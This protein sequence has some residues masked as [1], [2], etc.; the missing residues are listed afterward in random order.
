MKRGGIVSIFS[1]TGDWKDFYRQTPVTSIIFIINTFMLL[2]TLFTGGFD[3]R[4]SDWA[5]INKI[6][7]FDQGEYY[8]LL[9]GAFQ[10]WSILHY[11]M[12]MIIGIIVLSSALERVIGSKKFIAIYFGS[13]LISSYFTALL[14]SPLTNT[15]GASGAIFGVMGTLLWISFYR[16]DLL[17]YR[18]IQ[19]I[20][21]LVALQVLATFSSQDI[22]VIGHLSGIIGGFLLS[23][24]LIQRNVF[25]VL[26]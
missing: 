24:L 1:R 4:V 2:A 25:K 9:T 6:L 22:S 20:W 8:R 14:S 3:G 26:H 21:V 12:N 10:H 16:K 15:A 7:I 11:A 17:Y 18:D 23:Y 19:S 5:Y 13:L